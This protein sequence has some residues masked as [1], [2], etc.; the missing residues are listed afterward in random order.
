MARCQLTRA[1]QAYLQ[2]AGV[3]ENLKILVNSPVVK[4]LSSHAGPEFVASGV[5]FLFDGKTHTVSTTANGEV[6]L[7]AGCVFF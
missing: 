1:F 6:I 5:E 7:S 3:R 4:V 2:Q